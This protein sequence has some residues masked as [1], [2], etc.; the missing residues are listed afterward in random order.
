[1]KHF[2]FG[3]LVFV[4]LF[5][6]V[7]YAKAAP[8]SWDFNNGTQVLQPL[9]SG[10]GAQVK[11]A[12]FTATSTTASTFPYASTTAFSVS[13][14][15]FLGTTDGKVYAGDDKTQVL[16][17]PNDQVNLL[18][19]IFFGNGGISVNNTTG[20][21]GKFNV[22]IGIESLAGITTGSNNLG[23]G[24]RTLEDLTT[25]TNNN[26]MGNNALANITTTASNVGVGGSA[27]SAAT[28]SV[29]SVAI[30]FEAGSNLNPNSSVFI[31]HQAGKST[32]GNFAQNNTFL[33]YQTGNVVL[34][35]ANNNILIGYRAGNA[36]TTGANN[37][38][39]GYDIDPPSNTASNQLVIGNIIY[40]LNVNSTGTT[41]DPDALVG[42]GTST[43]PSRLTVQGTDLLNTTVNT[44][45]TGSDGAQT[46]GMTN[47]GVLYIGTST[48]AL[49][50]PGSGAPLQISTQTGATWLRVCREGSSQYCSG[51]DAS[52]GSF[53]FRQSGSGFFALYNGGTLSGGTVLSGTQDFAARAG[54]VIIGTSTNSSGT[55]AH[56]QIHAL[57]GFAHYFGVIDADTGS[58]VPNV[59]N[60]TNTERVGIGTTSPFAQ[61]S[62]NGY[63]AAT[64][65][66]FAVATSS[67]GFASTTVF[68]IQSTGEF[69]FG[70]M[71]NAVKVAG[72]FWYDVTQLAFAVYTDGG[73]Q[74]ILGR[75]LFTAT[76]EK[77]VTNTI[78]DTSA[79]GTGVGTKTLPANWCAPGKTT[80]IHGAGVYECPITGC[81]ATVK[82]KYATSTAA[83]L[84][85]INTSALLSTGTFNRYVFDAYVTTRTCG[86]A[87]IAVID[88]EIRYASGA[89][90]VYSTDA[91][92][93]AA[94]TTAIDTTAA[95]TFDVTLAW[96]TAVTTKIAT[97]TITTINLE[98]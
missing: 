61:V 63:P 26:A 17:I 29:A 69:L 47:G 64:L 70:A 81:T 1:M 78:A 10:W 86:A 34:S 72:E 33:G 9:Q 67:A 56:L 79:L 35:G 7:A 85:T 68:T 53:N 27:M 16:Y 88:G 42:I 59:F 77:V 21:E 5:L 94:V 15:T 62:I 90:G 8:V 2:L 14:N 25:G 43:P 41:V 46:W 95:G 82:V 3:L 23:M 92:N 66:L 55:L 75:T 52:N 24:Y 49:G 91:L 28:S 84:A 30:G 36:I 13:G 96:D 22:G 89:A 71:S 50:S 60:I 93:N 45:W 11:A 65:P 19:S 57:R 12:Y 32:A 37:L 74:T 4:L 39:L 98:N 54:T 58:A 76:A 97:T 38:V 48:A 40:G 18:G 80:R 44:T 83:T 31:G 6:F 51:W 87:A 20:N 73:V